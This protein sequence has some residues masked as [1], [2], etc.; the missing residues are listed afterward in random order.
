[1]DD[2]A[3]KRNLAIAFWLCY[4]LDAFSNLVAWDMNPK[5]SAFTQS[6]YFGSLFF[7]MGFVINILVPLT[8]ELIP[9]VIG[10]FIGYFKEAFTGKEYNIADIEA[11]NL[12]T[13]LPENAFKFK[14]P[15]KFTPS[16]SKPP[17]KQP[18]PSKPPMPSAPS[19]PPMF[20]APPKPPMPSAP[21]K[22]S[23]LKEVVK[24]INADRPQNDTR[25]QPSFKPKQSSSEIVKSFLDDDWSDLGDEEIKKMMTQNLNR[26][27]PD[28]FDEF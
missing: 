20:S 3:A 11:W 27:K 15:E 18:T 25:N 4:F 7:I 2:K 24:P 23:G 13:F 16:I 22:P 12:P 14:K 26:T 5:V 6:K 1:M 10:A 21:P 17:N 8:E 9:L 28:D 19:K